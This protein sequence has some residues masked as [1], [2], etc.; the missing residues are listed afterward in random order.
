MKII[1]KGNP[2]STNSIYKF[3]C[4]PFPRHYMN[5][6]GKERKE[7]YIWEATAQKKGPTLTGKLI[8]KIRLYFGDKRIRDWDNFHKLSMD[9][10]TEAGI[11]EDDKQVCEVNVI[12]DYDKE[13]PRIEIIIS[14]YK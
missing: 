13:D 7:E 14:E 5:K 4:T 8:L 10:L 1:L 6:A 3:A 2:L 12:K 11:W 9:A